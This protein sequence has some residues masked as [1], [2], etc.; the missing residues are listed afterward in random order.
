MNTMTFYTQNGHK[1][2]EEAAVKVIEQAAA[3]MTV[4]QIKR[5][6]G[7]GSML[8][9]SILEGRKPETMEDLQ[10][11]TKLYLL[12]QILAG[13]VYFSDLIVSGELADDNRSEAMRL[14]FADDDTKLNAFRTVGRFLMREERKGQRNG[15]SLDDE[16]AKQVADLTAGVE[17]CAIEADFR[18][19]LSETQAQVFDSMLAGYKQ[20][21]I[22]S[23]CGLSN[24]TASRMILSIKAALIEYCKA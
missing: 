20:A 16:E 10:S 21:E 19:T 13:T 9:M 17:F 15:Q 3:A 11:E 5:L 2:A 23:R 6:A 4:S 12:E 8:A 7:R 1:V 18:N 14:M 24:G 22:C